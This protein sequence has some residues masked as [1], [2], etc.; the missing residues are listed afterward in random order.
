MPSKQ[1]YISKNT[2]HFSS[3]FF[4]KTIKKIIKQ[5]FG[6]ALRGIPMMGSNPWQ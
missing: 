4:T 5:R 1:K 2:N 6:A 3:V